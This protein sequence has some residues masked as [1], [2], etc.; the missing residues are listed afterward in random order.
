MPGGE[1]PLDEGDSPLPRF[2]R[3]LRRLRADAGTPTYRELARR[4]HFSVPT[5]SD[6]TGGRELP[7]LDVTLPYVRACGGDDQAWTQRWH[8]VDESCTLSK[9]SPSP[10]P[11]LSE[12]TREDAD[13]FFGRENSPTP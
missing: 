4:A 5:L 1:R 3:N 2:A 11:G 9:T 13:R 12:F 8:E 7:G 6:A 10:C